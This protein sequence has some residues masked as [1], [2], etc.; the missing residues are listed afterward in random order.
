MPTYGPWVQEPDF[1]VTF[2]QQD[3]NQRHNNLDEVGIEWGRYQTQFFMEYLEGWYPIEDGS[4][5]AALAVAAES[6]VL[7]RPSNNVTRGTRLER[8]HDPG[9]LNDDNWGSGGRATIEENPWFQN[10][11]PFFFYPGD[12][13]P[14]SEE[15]PGVVGVEFEGDPR[16]VAEWLTC[17]LAASTILKADNDDQSD[18]GTGQWNLS[19]PAS[20]NIYIQSLAEA[21]SAPESGHQLTLFTGQTRFHETPLGVDVDITNHIVRGVGAVLY[22]RTSHFLPPS[23]A[24]N[25]TLLDPVNEWEYGYWI[26]RLDTRWRLR[27]PRYRW[28]FDTVPI[29]QTTHRDDHLAGGAYQT[30][31]APTSRQLSNTTFGG[32]L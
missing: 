9:A 1:D 2:R 16:G 21:S 4:M 18:T 30:W 31:P 15:P 32:Y 24:D 6:A 23:H 3:G 28:I 27:P 12:G 10:E 14:G 17:H 8:I 11:G 26:H 22:T 5:A 7:S 13:I 29:Q 20:T 25:Y 19:A